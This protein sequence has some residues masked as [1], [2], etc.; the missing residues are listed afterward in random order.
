MSEDLDRDNRLVSYVDSETE[1]IIDE[2]VESSSEST[3]VP[4]LSRSEA[5]LYLVR[6]GIES[7][8]E[9]V[10]DLV[11]DAFIDKWRITRKREQ[12]KSEQYLN[13]LKGG[14]RGRVLSQLNAR[15]SGHSPYSERHIRKHA[16]GLAE[17]AR[18][19][20]DSSDLDRNLEW[21]DEQVERYIDAARAKDMVPEDWTEEVDDVQVGR[22]LW[23]LRDRAK[24][25]VETIERIAESEA[26]DADAMLSRLASDFAV[27]EEAVELVLDMMVEDG[28]DTRRALKEG[29]GI[30]WY[31]RDEALDESETDGNPELVEDSLLPVDP[32][33]GHDQS[34]VDDAQPTPAGLTIDDS[35]EVEVE[36]VENALDAAEDPDIDEDSLTQLLDDEGVSDE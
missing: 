27:E 1:K 25:V 10:D 15:L 30:R 3:E 33:E 22:D 23:R 8:D 5:V 28:A 24:E 17:E 29:E 34:A 4:A 26:Y 13:D 19:Y 18:L 14:W 2:I 32:V 36:E 20:W 21:L 31:L 6:S 11:P 16:E 12:I 35:S 7:W 9:E